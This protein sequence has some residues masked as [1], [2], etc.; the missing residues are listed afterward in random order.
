MFQICCPKRPV[1]PPKSNERICTEDE[2]YDYFNND[3]NPPDC[4]L[5]SSE[6]PPPQFVYNTAAD[7][8]GGTRCVKGTECGAKGSL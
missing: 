8:P 5:P 4:I 6:D 3:D 2:V 7:C 1:L